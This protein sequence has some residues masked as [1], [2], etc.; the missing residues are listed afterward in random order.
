MCSVV[1][2][3]LLNICFSTLLPYFLGR[4]QIAQISWRLGRRSLL[5][6]S[7]RVCR[8]SDHRETHDSEHHCK[9]GGSTKEGK[10]VQVHVHKSY[11]RK[12]D[13]KLKF[14][15]LAVGVET[16]K[17]KS[18]NIISHAT[19]NDDACSSTFWPHPAPL[20]VNC[21]WC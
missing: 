6:L 21:S 1:L 16:I 20:Y 18:A 9:L 15:S 8:M 2:N 17:L 5:G 11:N 10:D 13:G 7:L 4:Q 12:F 3:N 19:C 14:D